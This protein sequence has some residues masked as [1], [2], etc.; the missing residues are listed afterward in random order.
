MLDAINLNPWYLINFFLKKIDIINIY[1]K[2]F[3]IRRNLAKDLMK[4]RVL[5]I[6]R[7]NFKSKI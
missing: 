6:D 5:V 7:I 2:V 1:F 4:E 3:I